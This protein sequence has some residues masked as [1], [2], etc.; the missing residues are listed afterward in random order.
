M[1][2][3]ATGPGPSIADLE[4]V[5]GDPAMQT[6]A[7]GHLPVEE[8]AEQDVAAPSAVTL[9][10]LDPRP[11]AVERQRLIGRPAHPR[12]QVLDAVSDRTA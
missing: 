2:G 5:G 7:A 11:A 12:S 8:Y 9:P 4:A 10:L 3:P 1:A 6:A